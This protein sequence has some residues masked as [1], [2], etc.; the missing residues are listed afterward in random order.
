MSLTDF[1][2]EIRDAIEGAPEFLAPRHRTAVDHL[3]AAIR[4]ERAGNHRVAGM[5]RIIALQGGK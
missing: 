3:D 4:F 5:F 1:S 2:I